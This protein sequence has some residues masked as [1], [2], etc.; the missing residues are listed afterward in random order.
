TGRGAEY[1]R[2]RQEVY[3]AAFAPDTLKVGVSGAGRTALRVLEQGAPAALI[4]GRADDGLAARRLEHHL[5]LL[6]ARERVP[7]RTKLRLLYPP[8]L[9][10]R[11]LAALSEAL[12]TMA[13]RLPRG[14]PSDVQRLDPPQP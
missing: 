7:V 9:A 12:A 3:R 8:P 4:V 2:S 13:A 10:D 1:R 11:L 14:W 5:G 6:G